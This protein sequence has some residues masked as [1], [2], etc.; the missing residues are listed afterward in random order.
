MPAENVQKLENTRHNGLVVSVCL[1]PVSMQICT[2]YE[3]S[4]I[5]HR[6]R[7]GNYRINDC[8][9]PNIVVGQIDRIFHLLGTYMQDMKVSMIKTSQD[10]PQM[11]QTTMI[12]QDGQF[13][14]TW[15]L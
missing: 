9:L 10:C 1:V 14:T 3:G 8:H 6:G 4:M 11:M 7:R 12:T 15:A 2:K 13:L 5:N